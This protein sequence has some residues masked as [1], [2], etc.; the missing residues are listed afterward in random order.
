MGAPRIYYTA[1]E[2]KAATKKSRH[3]YYKSIKY[4]ETQ[5]KYWANEYERRK[6]EQRK[7]EGD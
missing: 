2:R 5:L 4:A 7:S 6:A 1:E 3:I